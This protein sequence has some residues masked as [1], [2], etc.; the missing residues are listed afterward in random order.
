MTPTHPIHCPACGYDLSA[1]QANVG[2]CPECG[3]AFEKP[4]ITARLIAMKSFALGMIGAGVVGLLIANA[5]GNSV[6]YL[7]SDGRSGNG[8]QAA[9]VLQRLPQ[10]AAAYGVGVLAI[11]TGRTTLQRRWPVVVAA[12]FAICLVL[13]LSGVY[14][15]FPEY[16]RWIQPAIWIAAVYWVIDLLEGLLVVAAALMLRRVAA[17]RLRPFIH[18]IIAMGIASAVLGLATTLHTEYLY[19]TASTRPGPFSGA[20]APPISFLESDAMGASLR[21]LF[22]TAWWLAWPAL[23]FLALHLRALTRATWYPRP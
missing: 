1:V 22:S 19:A 16:S 2:T 15:A 6:A 11:T 12:I 8:E 17:P 9:Q 21:W 18:V 7:P 20:G 10:L 23:G 14:G 4:L 5:V 13:R 3:D